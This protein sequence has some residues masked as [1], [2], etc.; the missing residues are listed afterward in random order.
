MKVRVASPV[1]LSALLVGCVAFMVLAK[2][3]AIE[4]TFRY[5]A[6]HLITPSRVQPPSKRQVIP[7]RVYR[8]G[9]L[10][11]DARV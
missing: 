1:K 7:V 3:A 4:L 6:R 9:N 5:N 2:T 8:V 10:A 11:T